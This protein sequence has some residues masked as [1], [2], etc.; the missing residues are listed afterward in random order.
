MIAAPAAIRRGAHPAH[1][2][3]LSSTL[4]HPARAHEALDGDPMTEAEADKLVEQIRVQHPD[5][6]HV[7][8][9]TDGREEVDALGEWT[10]YLKD[11]ASDI[12]AYYIAPEEYADDLR[13]RGIMATRGKAR[14]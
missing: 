8:A 11:R 14:P 2:A 1:L 6:Q 12:D 3:R 9:V 7:M 13:A 4:P 5:A 10:V